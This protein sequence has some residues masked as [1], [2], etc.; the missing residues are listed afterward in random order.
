M[1]RRGIRPIP[2][3]L[4]VSS[5]GLGEPDQGAE[6]QDVDGPKWIQETITALAVT[7]L[8]NKIEDLLKAFRDTL[9]IV[10]YVA[11]LTD[12]MD[13][14]PHPNGSKDKLDPAVRAV[15]DNWNL[16]D[17]VAPDA[18]KG[19]SLDV[20]GT[21]MTFVIFLRKLLQIGEGFVTA[22]DKTLALAETDI[23]R[24]LQEIFKNAGSALANNSKVHERLAALA[25]LFVDDA[26]KAADTRRK[27]EALKT[28]TREATLAEVEQQ[29]AAQPA[30]QQ[31]P[32]GVQAYPGTPVQVPAGT[33][34]AQPGTKPSTKGTGTRSTP[35]SGRKKKP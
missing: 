8:G 31:A 33:H 28:N 4:R 16:L 26:L 6:Y 20:L 5:A 12:T 29:Q 13:S 11:D 7:V 19:Q 14:V 15:Q 30:P 35:R 32:Q 2:A 1:A 24:I 23:V 3:K 34:P 21:Q 10:G 22:V 18:V 9:D 17:T 27:N 25:A